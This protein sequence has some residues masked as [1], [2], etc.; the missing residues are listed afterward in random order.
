MIE[1]QEEGGSR[2]PG[3]VEEWGDGDEMRERQPRAKDD[4]VQKENTT[5]ER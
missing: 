1:Q 3:G 2:K 4:T 5:E